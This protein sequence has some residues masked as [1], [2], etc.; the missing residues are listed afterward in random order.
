MGDIMSLFKLQ[1]QKIKQIQKEIDILIST[2]PTKNIEFQKLNESKNCLQFL[3]ENDK[4][5]KLFLVEEK[6]EIEWTLKKPLS[7][8]EMEKF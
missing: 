1:I 8:I 2:L 3:L 4:L 6:G 7:K 5:E